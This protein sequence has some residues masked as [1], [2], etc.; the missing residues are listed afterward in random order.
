MRLE[1]CCLPGS[2]DLALQVRCLLIIEWGN[3]LWRLLLG[4]VEG[5]LQGSIPRFPTKHQTVNPK[6]DA[7]DTAI[8][9]PESLTKSP[10]RQRDT[11]Q[12]KP[13]PEQTGGPKY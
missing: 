9:P 3:G 5:L 1:S 7:T 12:M 6:F 11:P 8:R 13:R 4:I 2:T 10:N